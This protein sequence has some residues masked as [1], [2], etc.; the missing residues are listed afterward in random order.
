[1]T[2]CS[3]DILDYGYS[4]LVEYHMLQYIAHFCVRQLQRRFQ[5]H[6]SFRRTAMSRA[7]VLVLQLKAVQMSC[8]GLTGTTTDD[9]DLLVLI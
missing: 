4:I 8:Q 2:L 3:V 1:M 6:S 5:H 9:G 7:L